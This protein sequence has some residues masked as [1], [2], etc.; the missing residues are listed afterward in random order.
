MHLLVIS[1]DG[2]TTM[3]DKDE[4]GNSG[5]DISRMALENARGGGTMVLNLYGKWED[6]KDLAR[7]HEDG[8]QIS[9]VRT[10]EELVEFARQFSRMKYGQET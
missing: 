1:D 7:A 6:N 9:V 2:V 3:F 10:W 8:W 5:W 4:Q